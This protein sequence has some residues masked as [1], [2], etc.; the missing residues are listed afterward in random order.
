ME[1]PRQYQCSICEHNL[2]RAQWYAHRHLPHSFCQCGK[3]VVGDRALKYHNHSC[4]SGRKCKLCGKHL[5]K[6][7]AVDRHEKTPHWTC[8]KCSESM[9]LSARTKHE[10][11]CS[12]QTLLQRSTTPRDEVIHSPGDYVNS[13]QPTLPVPAGHS[14]LRDG[15]DGLLSVSTH[16]AN[17]IRLYK[18]R[19]ALAVG[20]TKGNIDSCLQTAQHESRT[21]KD[22]KAYRDILTTTSTGWPITAD[23]YLTG[24]LGDCR[25]KFVICSS[26]QATR[27]LAKGPP[28][29]PILIP[30]ELNGDAN[31]RIGIEEYLKVIE[32]GGEVDVHDFHLKARGFLPRRLMAST[33]IRRFRDPDRGPINLLNQAGYKKNPIPSC[34]S[35]LSD[36]DLLTT[37]DGLNGKKTTRLHCDLRESTSFQLLAKQGAVHLPHIDRHGVITTVFVEDGEKLWLCWP[38]LTIKDLEMVGH[39]KRYPPGQIALYLEPGALLIQPS[40]CLH[41]PYSITNVF[42]TGTM[43]LHS[44]SITTS[45]ECTLM[46]LKNVAISNEDFSQEYIVLMERVLGLWKERKGPWNWGYIEDHAYCLELLRVNKAAIS[47]HETESNRS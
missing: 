31:R 21:Q 3:W 7:K 8:T 38:G 12:G 9:L 36:Y 40:G 4:G 28:Q 41:A 29:L 33:A 22:L 17:T 25:G 23:E 11:K 44:G 46:E 47:S 24:N 37:I 14:L 1:A 16:I 13:S 34:I 26:Q 10:L 6:S 27:I 18:A 39:P 5:S 35:S 20:R 45:L 30:S 2:S 32:A 19:S 42:I 15:Q 43:H